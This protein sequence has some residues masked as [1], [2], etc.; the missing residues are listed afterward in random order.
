[1][2]HATVRAKM[3]RQ[4]DAATTSALARAMEWEF[5][6]DDLLVFIKM[7]PRKSTI[8]PYLLKVSFE[9]FPRRAPSYVFVAAETRQIDSS[10]WPPG[11]KHRD[12]LPGICTPGTRE[13]HEKW[14]KN[15]KKY[16]WNPDIYSF[17]DTL[18]RIQAMMEAAHK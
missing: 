13:C 16:P 11:V 18:C 3:M 8:S 2:D 17:L 12:T 1:M 4:V 10:G 9:D 15:D 7:R 6:V 14:H 5:E